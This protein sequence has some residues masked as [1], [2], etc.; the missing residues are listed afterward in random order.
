MI[1]SGNITDIY[2]IRNSTQKEWFKKDIMNP[3]HHADTDL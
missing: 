3:G 2:G 1:S